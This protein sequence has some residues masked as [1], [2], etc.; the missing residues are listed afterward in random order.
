MA[1]L[2]SGGG[3]GS[4]PASGGAGS[5]PAAGIHQRAEVLGTSGMDLDL[6][7]EVD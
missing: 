2:A 1:Q 3:A 6:S 5:I 7:G 4:I